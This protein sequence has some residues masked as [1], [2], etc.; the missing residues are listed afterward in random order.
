LEFLSVELRSEYLRNMNFQTAFAVAICLSR[1][2]T[3]SK[4]HLHVM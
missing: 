3:G 4:K 2:N 1:L